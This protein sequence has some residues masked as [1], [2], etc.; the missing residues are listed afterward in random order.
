MFHLKVRSLSLTFDI[1]VFCISLVLHYVLPSHPN[2]L[3]NF[4]QLLPVSS[5]S[6]KPASSEKRPSHLSTASLYAG[7]YPSLS[8]TKDSKRSPTTSRIRDSGSNFWL[9]SSMLR[10]TFCNSPE[11]SS[12]MTLE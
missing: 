2:F 6:F 5:S 3:I 4:G 1:S 9:T 10:T 11:R 12:H 7:V 8:Q